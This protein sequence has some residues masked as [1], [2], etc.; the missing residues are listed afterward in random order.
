MLKLAILSIAALAVAETVLIH[1]G[2]DD[3][4][5]RADDPAEREQLSLCVHR[6]IVLI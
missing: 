6:V 5:I 4:C 2:Q 1:P 3:W